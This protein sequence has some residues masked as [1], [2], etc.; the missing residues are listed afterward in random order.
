[1]LEIQME[2]MSKFI[3]WLSHKHGGI[4]QP[5][6]SRPRATTVGFRDAT[7]STHCGISED[8]IGPSKPSDMEPQ[9]AKNFYNIFLWL[10]QFFLMFL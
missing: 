8:G 1:M 7:L 2:Y 10:N 3:S 5:P 6:I 4:F 9:V